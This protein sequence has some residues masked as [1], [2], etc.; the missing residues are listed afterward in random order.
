MGARIRGWSKKYV[1]TYL[2]LVVFILTV[3][4]LES[5]APPDMHAMQ[6][7]RRRQAD[8]EAG[9]KGKA[10]AQE[11]VEA[12]ERDSTTIGEGRDE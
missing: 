12:R 11:A 3:M 6:I 1:Y 7:Q 2:Y 10:P 4:I 5:S 8:L 9:A